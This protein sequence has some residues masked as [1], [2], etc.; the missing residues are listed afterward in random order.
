MNFFLPDEVIQR[1]EPAARSCVCTPHEEYRN[2]KICMA[3]PVLD[4]W[5]FFG[6]NVSDL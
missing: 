4:I 5:G 2:L 3:K 6:N 1:S